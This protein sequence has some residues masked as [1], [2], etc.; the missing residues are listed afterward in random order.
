MSQRLLDVAALIGLKPNAFM[1]TGDLKTP[2]FEFSWPTGKWEEQSQ[3]A[4]W[5][6]NFSD[7]C[8][9][10]H[11]GGIGERVCEF[12]PLFNESFLVMSCWCTSRCGIPPLS[13]LARGEV[14]ALGP[15]LPTFTE[16]CSS[17]FPLSKLQWSFV[18]YLF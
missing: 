15:F 9:P 10:I 16:G 6:Q 17:D 12:T 13:R 1:T 8:C 2:P 7:K 11:R 14:L 3:A 5:F 4:G 18:V